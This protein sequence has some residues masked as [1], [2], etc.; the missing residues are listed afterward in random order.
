MNQDQSNTIVYFAQAILK[1]LVEL[2]L[3]TGKESANII[4]RSADYYGVTLI[5]S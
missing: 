3:L 2:G 4:N 1:R 5:V